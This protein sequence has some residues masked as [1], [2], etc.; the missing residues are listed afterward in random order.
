MEPLKN[1]VARPVVEMLGEHFE[2]EAPDFVAEQFVRRVMDKLPALELKDRINLIAAELRRHLDD[3]YVPALGHVVAVATSGVEGFA[4]WP[5]C[6]FVELFG[7]DHPNESLAAMEHLTQRMSCEFAIR[8]FLDHHLNQT[9]AQLEAWT[10]HPDAAVRRLVS[11]GTR[12]RLPWGPRVEALTKNPDIGLALIERLR[13]DVSDDV[14]RSVANHLNDIAKE[15]PERVVEVARR[16]KAEG[17][18]SSLISH[19]L[20]TLVKKGDRGALAVL[21]FTTEA[22]VAVDR[23]D[24]VPSEIRLGSTIEL[25][26]ELRSTGPDAQRLVVDFVV[27]HPSGSGKVSTKVFKWATIGLESGETAE[28]KKQ[29][30]IA[31]M[32]TRTY[33]LGF[34]EI[35]LQV[36]GL[37]V[38]RSGFDLIG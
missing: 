15:H 2:R 23:F 7:V 33:Q 25:I 9:I 1:H 14:R 35:E 6:S 18:S 12:P 28:L 20:R 27:H 3:D 13:F 30:K 19:A 24:V 37:T 4:A 38:G 21:G 29:R 17:V 10:D 16:W 11:E 36:A 34:H 22:A 8:P 32:S 31:N 26:A 5:L